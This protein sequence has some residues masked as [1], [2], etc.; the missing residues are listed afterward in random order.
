MKI[1]LL[2]IGTKEGEPV[3]RDVLYGAWCKGKRV[4]FIENPP[5]SLLSVNTFL[6]KSHFDTMFLDAQGL[7]LSHDEIIKKINWSDVDI[8]I[9]QTATM[10]FKDDTSLLNRIKKQ[11]PKIITIVFGSHVTFM[12]EICLKNKAI[13]FIVRFEPEETTL[14]LITNL[15][16]SKPVTNVQNIGYRRKRKIIITPEA[17]SLDFDKLPIPNREPILNISY[18]HP[19]AIRS[20]CTNVETSRGCPMRCTFCTAHVFFRKSVKERNIDSVVEELR[21]L[22]NLGYKEIV[23]RD[24]IFTYDRERV[25]EICKRIIQEDIDLK[26]ICN[27]FVGLVDEELMKLMKKAGCHMILFGIESGSQKILANIKKGFAIGKALE[28]FKIAK[29]VGIDTHAHFI[30][31]CPGET[32]ETIKETIKL[33]KKLNPTTAAFNILTIYPGS[34]LHE[35]LRR[36]LPKNWDS[37]EADIYKLHVKSFYS[38]LITELKPD[39][40]EKCLMQAYREFYF[41]PNYI[42]KR[43]FSVKSFVELLSLLKSGFGVM[44]MVLTKKN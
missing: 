22:Q 37:T 26:W 30:L 7:K 20:P 42:V 13:D 14:K 44:S 38:E 24:E 6:N 40:L 31:G 39:V 3:N 25:I 11:N 41:R 36:R 9:T 2:N 15:S 16:L 8:V 29:R 5:L 32:E 28:T 12:P 4:G 27:G 43:I 35:K 19:F 23:F 33:A 17:P 1:L 21:Y 10:T 18:Y 34:E